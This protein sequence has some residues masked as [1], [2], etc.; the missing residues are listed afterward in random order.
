[1]DKRKP[2]YFLTEVQQLAAE[3]RFKLTISAQKT[4]DT[5]GFSKK[6]VQDVL[7][8]LEPKNFYKS[9]TEYENHAVWQ[10]VYRKMVNDVEI[11]VKLKVSS[12]DGKLLLI[13][14]FK[15]R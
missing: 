5:L 11:Y 15:P 4:A 12:I 3:G 13:L 14:S 2:T 6:A 1:M 7:V 8:T 9:T 10:D